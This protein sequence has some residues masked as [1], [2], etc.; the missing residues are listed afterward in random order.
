MAS[1]AL[2]RPALWTLFAGA[3][4]SAAACFSRLN[5]EGPNVTCADL[6]NGLINACSEGIIASCADGTH[7]T[8]EVCDDKDAC[9]A[10]WQ[11]RGAYSCT[12]LLHGGASG[13]GGG[14]SGPTNACGIDW[15]TATCAA[16]I[17]R[18]CCAAAMTCSK[19]SQCVKCAQNF[20]TPNMCLPKDTPASFSQELN[21]CL[22]GPCPPG[23]GICH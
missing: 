5:R 1:M 4:L 13:S 3:V 7:V 10:S 15:S 19:D 11:T 20:N 8:Y 6:Q 18:N 21:A 17:Q 22:H 2:F 23:V 16:C 9:G 12:D 14:S